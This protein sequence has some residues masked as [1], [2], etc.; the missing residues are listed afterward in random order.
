MRLK[1]DLNGILLQL[2][3]KNYAQS[4]NNDWHSKWCN[5]DFSVSSRKWLNYCCEDDE[6]LL[7]CEVET[8]AESIDKLLNDELD[9]VLELSCIEPDFN[10][11]F[12]PKRDLRK[13]PKYIYIR[14]GCEI[15]DAYMEWKISFWNRGLTDN[16][17]SVTLDRADLKALLVY[18]N[19]I[20]GKLKANDCEV[21]EFVGRGYLS[22]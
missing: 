18:L 21:V 15:A 22:D 12:H 14:D 4:T 1:I 13:D 8:L 9:D 2:R 16:Y 19:F 3:I 20:I 11:V 7:S 5:V 17:L 6:V 10:F